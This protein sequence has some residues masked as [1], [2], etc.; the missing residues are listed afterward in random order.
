MHVHQLQSA[1]LFR[2]THLGALTLSG[3]LSVLASAGCAAETLDSDTGRILAERPL[4]HEETV[5]RLR[6]GKKGVD[7]P[8]TDEQRVKVL[9]IL[10]TQ[11]YKLDGAVFYAQDVIVV[12][13]DQIID[14]R[15]LL[16]GS[17]SERKKGR[18]WGPAEDPYHAYNVSGNNVVQVLWQT[19]APDGEWWWAFQEAAEEYR[20][21][22][23]VYMTYDPPSAPRSYIDVYATAYVGATN[24]L[25]FTDPYRDINDPG[26]IGV[27]TNFNGLYAYHGTPCYV[28]NTQSLPYWVKKWV[29]LH[30]LGHA[31]GFAHYND[32][33][34]QLINNT[35][36][37]T[38]G[39]Y[40]TVM[41]PACGWNGIDELSNDD[42]DMVDTVYYD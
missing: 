15:A 32:P 30:E 31:I 24:A 23:N 17:L 2:A 3:A 16:A 42:E 34:F 21:H 10:R 4:F 14:A 26:R 37:D 40:P 28:S 7:K 8:L 20:W 22:T 5:A 1:W 41:D 29:A 9:D 13:R 25:A 12:E 11:G 18:W 27:N 38:Q 36:D 35:A 6:A 19:D 39:Y 33:A